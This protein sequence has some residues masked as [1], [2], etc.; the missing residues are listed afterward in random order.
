[1]CK[2]CHKIKCN[3]RNS[4]WSVAFKGVFVDIKYY[5]DEGIT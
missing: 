2:S 4:E 5:D 3:A 1:M